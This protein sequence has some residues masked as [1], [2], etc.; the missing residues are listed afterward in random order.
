MRGAGVLGLPDIA[1]VG[2]AT[3]IKFQALD[4]KLPDGDVYSV[5]VGTTNKNFRL[6]FKVENFIKIMSA[7]YD[8]KIS[9]KGISHLK[10]SE[11]EYWI[12]LESSS[13][14]DA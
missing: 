6:I 10:S 1:V 5:N 7:D 13:S 9:S 4:S 14:Y 3:T 12:A 8:V 11:I 2:D